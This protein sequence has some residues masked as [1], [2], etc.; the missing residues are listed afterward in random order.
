MK[1]ITRAAGF[2]IYKEENGKPFYLLL[3]AYRNWDFPK[4]TIQSGESDFEAALRETEEETTLNCFEFPF[5][6]ES[7]ETEVYSKGK[8]SKFFI[9]KL[10]E[11]E[12]VLRPSPELGRAEHHEWRWVNF[13]EALKLLPIHLIPILQWANARICSRKTPK[14]EA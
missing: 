6:L 11:G 14:E 13:E 12:P 10:K 9:A 3:R 1:K 5:N 2:V 4:G 8:I 7:K